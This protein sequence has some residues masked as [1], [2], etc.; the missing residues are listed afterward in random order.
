MT[1]A[2]VDFSGDNWMWSIRL[3]GV[4]LRDLLLM[5]LEGIKIEIFLCLLAGCAPI[6]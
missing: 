3:K 1:V 5:Y 2:R 4:I 6:N